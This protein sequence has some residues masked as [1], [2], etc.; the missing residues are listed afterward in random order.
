MVRI[1]LGVIAGFFVWLIVWVGSERFFR[2]FGRRGTA[3]IK[4]RSKRQLKVVVS[5]QRTRRCFS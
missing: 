4:P 1:V 5:S 3:L 2:P